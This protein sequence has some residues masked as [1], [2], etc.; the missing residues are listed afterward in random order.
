MLRFKGEDRVGRYKIVIL[1][2][3]SS[4]GSN[5]VAINR[6]FTSRSIPIDIDNLFVTSRKAP[7]IERCASFGIKHTFLSARDMSLYQ[8]KLK[9]YIKENSIDLIVLAGFM[10]LLTG[11]FID[12]VGVPI[13]N[14]HPALLPNYG[15]KGMYGMNVHNAVFK[16]KEKFSGVTIH[17]VNSKYD[18]GEVILQKRVRINR[19]KSAKLIAK[20]VLKLE[21]A[22]YGRVIWSFLRRY[23]D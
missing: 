12:S 16:A 22:Y 14:I 20:R 5:F 11:D 17:Q 7:V 21:H 13:L 3:G 15:G 18:E 19:Y 1:T 10:K 2:S 6:Y 4:R 8:E 9:V 23:N